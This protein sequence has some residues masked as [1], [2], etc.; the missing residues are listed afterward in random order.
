MLGKEG[1]PADRGL[2]AEHLSSRT[3]T[4]ARKH[5]RERIL[6]SHA[7]TSPNTQHRPPHTD[8]DPHL[9]PP[10]FTP[11]FTQLKGSLRDCHL[12]APTPLPQPRHTYIHT[13]QRQTFP[14]LTSIPMTS[15]HNREK[16]SGMLLS[17]AGSAV[18][19]GSGA[20]A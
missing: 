7:R 5:S 14:Q 6:I 17:A 19:P 3:G 16:L 13:N 9:L 10:R 1:C 18:G 12:P 11:L 4:S 2:T 15:V 8:N 20:A